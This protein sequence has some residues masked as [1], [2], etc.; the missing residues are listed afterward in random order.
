VST[1]VTD[2]GRQRL[3]GIKHIVVLMM[4]NRSFDH[5]LGYLG[6]EEA[7]DVNGLQHARPNEH[8]GQSYPP[9]PL[10]RTEFTK[11]EDPDHS[12]GSVAVQIGPERT[13]DG[14]VSAY[15]TALAAR[16]TKLQAAGI[17]PDL[18]LPMGHY[19]ATDVPAYDFLARAYCVCDAWHSSVPGDTWPNRLYSLAGQEGTHALP[20]LRLIQRL[21][22][23]FGRLPVWKKLIGAPIYDVPAFTRHLDDAQWR[24]YS[25]DPATLRAADSRYRDFHPKRINRGNFAYFDRKKIGPFTEAL[26]SAIVTHDSFLDDAARGQLR[27]VSWI[28]PNFID[29]RVLETDSNDDHPPSDIHAGQA[30]VLEL[31]DA[32]T[33]TPDWDDTLL[34][35]V[36][37]EHGG[38]YDHVPPPPVTDSANHTTY[39]VRVPALLIGP[40]VPHHVNHE[41]FDHTSLIK[42]ILLRFAADPDGA[43][44]QMPARVQH[45]THLGTALSD[46]PRHDLPDHAAVQAQLGAWHQEARAKRRLS[47]TTQV[48]T[49][50]DGA[51]RPFTPSDFQEDFA[52]TA[53]ALRHAGLPPGQP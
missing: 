22:K 43:L 25:H 1:A 13:M 19:T 24:W 14:F 49:A 12:V 46:T 41:L 42:T 31:Y 20:R 17:T 52:K 23:F 53:L 47:A 50:P 28:D 39:G 18:G 9:Q 51:G 5:M 35:I 34:V 16:T 27:D 45:A 33:K 4:E 21:Q 3:Q 26:E 36:Y 7:S 48:S 30:L 40:R 2:P 6:L 37:D 11:P 29:L 32:L 15:V 44:A 8:A 38:F 10:T